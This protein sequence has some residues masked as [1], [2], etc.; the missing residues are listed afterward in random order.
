M[1]RKYTETE[2]K[3]Y[4]AAWDWLQKIE[5]QL[6]EEFERFNRNRPSGLQGQFALV[7]FKWMLAEIFKPANLNPNQR[8]AQRIVGIQSIEFG[9]NIATAVN[10]LT[11]EEMRTG[12]EFITG[13]GKKYDL[14]IWRPQHNRITTPFT[15]EIKT[16]E[17]QLKPN[18]AKFRNTA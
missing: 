5:P 7:R 12:S 8:R 9:T 3:A 16:L 11:D 2:I 4:E 18:F 14:K 10:T 6:G 13:I 15:P 17:Y 1:T